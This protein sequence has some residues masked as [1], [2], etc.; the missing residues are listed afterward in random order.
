M[1]SKRQARGVDK[2]A[3]SAVTDGRSWLNPGSDSQ[4]LAALGAACVQHSTA[5]TGLHANQEAVGTGA[6]DFGRLVGAFHDS[7]QS[8]AL[9]TTLQAVPA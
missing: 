2:P 9:E 5:A 8:G 6:F 1:R 3:G 4:A 7:V